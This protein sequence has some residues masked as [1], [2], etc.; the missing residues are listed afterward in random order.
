MVLS[1]GKISFSLLHSTYISIVFLKWNSEADGARGASEGDRAGGAPQQINNKSAKNSQDI[2][3]IITL[4]F[5]NFLWVIDTRNPP[6]NPGYCEEIVI[7]MYNIQHF[8]GRVSPQ[9]LWT[10]VVV[11]WLLSNLYCWYLLKYYI[12][13]FEL[14][15]DT[16]NQYDFHAN[17]S[18]LFQPKQL[19]INQFQNLTANFTLCCGLLFIKLD[20]SVLHVLK[21]SVIFNTESVL[22]NQ[23]LLWQ[24]FSIQ[25]IFCGVKLNGTCCVFADC[26]GVWKSCHIQARK[27]TARSQRTW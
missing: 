5:I 15:V 23:M 1:Q 11:P 2:F 20:L 8:P 17:Y 10:C 9:T 12:F 19:S 27:S 4:N 13:S 7:Y 21:I 26:P 16:W 18:C 25:N 3:T 6:N 22:P 14:L 24:Y